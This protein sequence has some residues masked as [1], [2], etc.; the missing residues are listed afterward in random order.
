MLYAVGSIVFDTF[1]LNVDQVS[2]FTG[3]DGAPGQH[4]RIG[5]QIRIEPQ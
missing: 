4:G 5:C 2:R 3:G 1:P